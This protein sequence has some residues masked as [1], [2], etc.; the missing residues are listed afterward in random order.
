MSTVQERVTAR[1]SRQQGGKWDWEVLVDGEPYRFLCSMPEG[2]IWWAT[3]NGT[4]R[5][6]RSA[7]RKARKYARKAAKKLQRAEDSAPAVGTAKE[8]AF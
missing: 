2:P 6:E 1:I 5:F 8:L 4:C 3:A 7:A